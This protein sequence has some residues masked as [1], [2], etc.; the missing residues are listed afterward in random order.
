MLVHS[1]TPRL[2]RLRPPSSSLSSVSFLMKPR[3]RNRKASSRRARAVE[4]D[5]ATFARSLARAFRFALLSDFMPR[6]GSRERGFPLCI[7]Y[8][9]TSRFRSSRDLRPRDPSLRES[10]H[11]AQGTSTSLLSGADRARRI[12]RQ[13]DV[14]A[15]QPRST[16]PTRIRRYFQRA[17]INRGTC[18][19]ASR[20]V[21]RP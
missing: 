7:S 19:L 12:P 8:L 11:R 21:E 20:G 1:E 6:S 14:N 15:W 4:F 18:S 3:L 9:D 2:R 5:H 16:N 13:S 10:V 17:P